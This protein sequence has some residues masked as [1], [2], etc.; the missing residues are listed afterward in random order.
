MKIIT[1]Y[2]FAQIWVPALLSAG[3][4]A[5]LVTAAAIRDNIKLLF[6][7]VPFVQLRFLDIALI[8]GFSLPS[9]L[10]YVLPITFMFGIMFAFGKLAV[11]SELTALRA[12]GIGLN[13]LVTSILV[14]GAVLSVLCFALQNVAQPWS[15]KRLSDLITRDV[16]LRMTI[17]LLPVGVMHEFG[18]WQVYVG[19]RGESGTLTGLMMLQ[20][21][22]DG[23]ATTFYA[24]RA[25]LE[26]SDG[27]TRIVMEHGHYIPHSEGGEVRRVTFSSLSKT[28]P[29]YE[30]ADAVKVRQALTIDELIASEQNYARRYAE[31]NA[32]PV[33]AELRKDRIEIGLRFSMPLMCLAAA[34][35]AA[36]LGARTPRS[37]RSYAFAAGIGIV[38]VYFMLVNLSRPPFVPSLG[39]A[40]AMSQIPNVV[41]GVLGA[42]AIWRVD[43]V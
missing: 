12:S 36:P 25:R 6:L 34:A 18:G 15:M 3:V 5:F 32:L 29:R 42:I 20:P 14:F 22:P 43:R 8:A 16:P 30:P 19:G 23:G 35:L 31:T 9:T 24:E 27:V 33:L 7:E 11:N 1:R 38:V 2:L 10:N 17:D 40:V 37:G 13:Q 26:N 41:L 28:I 21:E 4:V 39:V